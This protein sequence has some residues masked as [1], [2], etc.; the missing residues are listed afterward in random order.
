VDYIEKNRKAGGLY[1]SLNAEELAKGFD[2]I[3][4]RLVSLEY[5]QQDE[6][7]SFNSTRNIELQ[8]PTSYLEAL[9]RKLWAI[10]QRI[11]QGNPRVT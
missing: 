6:S 11:N 4:Q 7:K 10:P 8:Y 2:N 3:C 5:I 1:I 9:A